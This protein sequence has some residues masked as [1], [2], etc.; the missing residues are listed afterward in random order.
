MVLNGLCDK[1]FS[2]NSNGELIDE[3]PVIRMFFPIYGDDYWYTFGEKAKK[4]LIK[5]TLK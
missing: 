3:V 1:D 2:I 5:L 4:L